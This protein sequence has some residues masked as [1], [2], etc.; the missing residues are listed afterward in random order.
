MSFNP[1]DIEF[2][3]LT[4]D[5]NDKKLKVNEIHERIIWY[6]TCDVLAL[7]TDLSKTKENIDRFNVLISKLEISFK[8][9]NNELKIL[10]SGIKSKLNPIY[11][12]S[13]KQKELRKRKKR[14]TIEFEKRKRDLE[15]YKSEYSTLVDNQ[16]RIKSEIRDYSEFQKEIIIESEL[17]L[18]KKI[19]QLEYKLNQISGDK[20]RVD[21]QLKPVIELIDKY[22]IEDKQLR[23]GLQMAEEYEY[24]LNTAYNSYERKMIHDKCE[25]LFGIGSPKKIIGDYNRKIKQNKRNLEKAEKRATT[26]GDKASRVIKKIV[27]DGNN[28]CYSGEELLGIEP[29]KCVINKLSNKYDLVL[30]F[31]ASISKIFQTKKIYSLFDSVQSHIVQAGKQADEIIIEIASNDDQCYILSN[32]RFG[33]YRDKEVI[34]N[35]R[36]INHEIVDN[37]VIITDLGI[38]IKYQ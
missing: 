17:T 34:Y 36:I 33:D 30:V 15:K 4:T 24:D 28:L 6:E 11:Y 19:E 32:D 21:I 14:I 22:L 26:I 25:K 29:L 12:F 9:N 10:D 8:K 38:N 13:S 35:K 20:E 27:I 2:N 5:I 23:S 37:K 31:D 7:E 16:H 1:Y 18:L 3:K